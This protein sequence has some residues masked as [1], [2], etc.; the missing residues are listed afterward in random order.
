MD[1]SQTRQRIEEL[2]AM[3][4]QHNK[5]YYVLNLPIISDFEFDTLMKELEK[6]EL[7]NPHLDDLLSPTHRVGN[8]INLEFLQRQHKYPMLSLGNTYSTE[9]LLDFDQRVRKNLDGKFTYSSELKY[10]GTAISLTYQKGRLVYAVTRG[11]GVRGDDVTENVKTIR[12]IPLMLN[13]NDYP[14]E[15]EIRGEIFMTKG[16]FARL[17]NER[18]EN[19]EP[20]FA[21]PRN[22]ASGSLKMINSSQVAQRPLDCFLYHMAGNQLPYPTHTK[23]LQKAKEWGF[24]IPEN[25]ELHDSIDGVLGFIQK[26]AADRKNLPFEIDGIVIKLNDLGQ[27]RVLGFTSKSPRWAISYKFPAE[28]VETVLESVDFQVGRT[29]TVTPVANLKPV[30]LAGTTVKRA[31][32][33]NAD[34]INMLD[35]HYGDLVKIE[36][37]GEIIPKIVGVNTKERLAGSLTVEFI[38]S[39]PECGTPLLRETGEVRHYCPN[40]TN[41]P[42]QI[43]GRIEHFISRKALNIDGLGQETVDLLYQNKLL[44]SVADLYDLLPENLLGLERL[45]EKSVSNILNS[46]DTSK[47]VPFP[48]VLYGI[49]I[50]YVGETVAKKLAQAMKSMDNLISATKEQLLEVN[51]IG[52]RIA[53]SLL[54]YFSIQENLDMIEKLRENG[55]KME[56]GE[57]SNPHSNILDGKSFV[58]SGVFQKL[59]RDELKN[60]IEEYGG[61]NTGSI[62]AKTSY[63]I[64][65]VNMGPAKLEKAGKLGISILSELDFLTMIDYKFS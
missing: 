8:D 59:S 29:G 35:L 3:L 14:D 19:G 26:W 4:N 24:K 32:I 13:G 46:L 31:S 57:S 30:F 43:K 15:F 47:Q 56:V 53:D 12:S 2:R 44:R 18:E 48:R 34:Q 62:S 39:C 6:L 52:E 42:P 55:L 50:R 17:N 45:G 63:I 1:I 58:V 33:H 9:D 41:C 22:A 25:I 51:E 16:G 61:K 36:K 54:D 7:E 27:Q 60:L 65:G 11:D 23:N 20:P 28:Q 37:G 49:G 40:T 38:K 21:N 5:Q 64:A 10:D